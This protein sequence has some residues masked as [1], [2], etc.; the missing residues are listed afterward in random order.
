MSEP[1]ERRFEPGHDIRPLTLKEFDEVR[2]YLRL[3]VD[4]LG[5]MLQHKHGIKEKAALDDAV[6]GAILQ[7]VQ[8]PTTIKTLAEERPSVFDILSSTYRYKAELIEVQRKMMAQMETGRVSEK[9]AYF[10]VFMNTHPNSKRIVAD[11]QRQELDKA[12]QKINLQ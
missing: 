5:P 2:A 10:N 3:Q 1:V 6:K 4:A 9:E 8:C 7:D 11:L 12:Q